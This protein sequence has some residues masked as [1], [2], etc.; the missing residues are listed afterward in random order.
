[1]KKGDM[2]N[3]V[4]SEQWKVVRPSRNFFASKL[5]AKDSQRHWSNSFHLLARAD[6]RFESENVRGL[7]QFSQSLQKVIKDALNEENAN[8]LKNKGESK[9]EKKEEVLMRGFS[10][11]T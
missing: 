10:P 8:L 6:G 11:T 5:S 1:M 2:P 7:D 4:N 3:A 9:M